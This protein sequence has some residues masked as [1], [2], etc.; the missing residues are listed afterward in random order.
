MATGSGPQK[1]DGYTAVANEIM[2]A[3][4]KAPLRGQQFRCLMFLF[5][6]TYGFNKKEDK[7]SLSEWE[8]GTGMKRQ[9]VWRELE[10]LIKCNVIY[11]K[12]SGPKRP[13]TWGFNKHYKDWNLESVIADDDKSV[14]TDDYSPEPS[15]ISSDDKSVITPH[16]RTKETKSKQQPAAFVDDEDSDSTMALVRLAYQDVCGV[17]PSTRTDE[18]KATL[19]TASRLIDRYGFPTC[20]RGLS[21]VKERNQAMI[22]KNVRNR[23]R[24]PIAYL[25][26]LLEDED[27]PPAEAV[28][29][30][31]VLDFALE[32]TYA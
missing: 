15:V 32:D 6:K 5:R 30:D 8:K 12:S 19:L 3:L 23:I 10:M 27:T 9:N 16:E 24:N 2:E 18:G 13:N 31:S 22:R 17:G 26:T 1:E 4:S 28:M 29:A 20:L 21:T 7:I 14:I 25:E 11:K